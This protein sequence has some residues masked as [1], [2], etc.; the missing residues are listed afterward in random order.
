MVTQQK[1]TVIIADDDEEILAV[2]RDVVE[3]EGYRVVPA[4]DG[5][6]LLR[7]VPTLPRPCL[8]L[9][10]IKMPKVNGLE[11]LDR[12]QSKPE[13][14]DVPIVLFTDTLHPAGH[15]RSVGVLNKPVSLEEL[16][17]VLAGHCGQPQPAPSRTL[18]G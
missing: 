16:L 1:G 18:E 5:E 2:V 10:D 17:R 7:L 8:V 15:P 14:E 11:F 4:H 12:I 3:E 13:W 6:E 9:L